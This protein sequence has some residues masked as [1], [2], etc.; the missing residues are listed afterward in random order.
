MLER[1]LPQA[2]GTSFNNVKPLLDMDISDLQIQYPLNNEVEND[3]T[4]NR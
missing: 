1:S 2:V 4:L 3:R